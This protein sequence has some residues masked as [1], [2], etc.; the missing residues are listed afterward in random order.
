[1]EHVKK[2]KT[3]PANMFFIFFFIFAIFIL[4]SRESELYCYIFGRNVRTRLGVAICDMSGPLLFHVK[5]EA[6]PKVPCPRTQQA[7][8]PACSPQPPLNAE[9]QAGKLWIPFFKVFWY[10]STRG[11]NPRS[12]D[13]EADA[14]TTTPSRRLKQSIKKEDDDETLVLHLKDQQVAPCNAC[15]GIVGKEERLSVND[16]YIFRK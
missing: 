1:M 4:H 14:L 9:C 12:T 16:G 5:A 2:V 8:F 6:S 3:Y 15:T 13:C 7:N 10:D 11:L